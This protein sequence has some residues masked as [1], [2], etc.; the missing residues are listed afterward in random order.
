MIYNRFLAFSITCFCYDFVK[1]IHFLVIVL[2]KKKASANL[3]SAL[4]P[5][6]D[7]LMGNHNV[8]QR[9]L[10]FKL[11]IL[12]FQESFLVSVTIFDIDK[13]TCSEYLPVNLKT[14]FLMSWASLIICFL[15]QLSINLYLMLI[16]DVG[17]CSHIAY[18]LT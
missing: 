16:I 2:Y 12:Q 5:V 15:F 3:L 1:D 7:Q 6:S 14:S 13:C 4:H 18:M 11:H 9:A 10:P 17:V 8:Y